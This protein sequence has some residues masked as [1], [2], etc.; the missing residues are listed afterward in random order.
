MLIFYI[1]KAALRIP[2]AQPIKG[3]GWISLFKIYTKIKFETE[4]IT[5][6]YSNKSISSNGSSLL[7]TYKIEDFLSTLYF[8]NNNIY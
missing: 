8:K 2:K 5:Q 3:R 6:K 7:N 1:G 4:Y